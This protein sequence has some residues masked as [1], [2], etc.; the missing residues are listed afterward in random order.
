MLEQ[1]AEV[2][3]Q[4]THGLYVTPWARD[5]DFAAKLARSSAVRRNTLGI[6]RGLVA[7]KDRDRDDGASG[8]RYFG[9]NACCW[10]LT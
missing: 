9:L 2:I 3:G 8:S 1:L 4:I 6:R 7:P 10:R 5:P